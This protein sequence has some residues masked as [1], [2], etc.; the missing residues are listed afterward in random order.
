[1]ESNYNICLVSCTLPMD[2]KMV[3]VWNQ[4]NEELLKNNYKLFLLTTSVHKDLKCEHL[5]IP[6]SL[7]EFYE[8]SIDVT[9]GID[10]EE[11]V[12]A[13]ELT[14]RELEWFN[15]DDQKWEKH[16]TGYFKCKSFYRSIIN[17]LNPS[18]IVAWQ[19][20]LPQSNI[21]KRLGEEYSIP[22]FILE[23]G[24]LPDTFMLESWGNVALS[25]LINS[26]AVRNSILYNND[27]SSFVDIQKYYINNKPA[28]YNQKSYEN[29]LAELNNF[30]PNANH[31][32]V[33]FANV[34]G[35]VGLYPEDTVLSRKTSV[36][37]RNSEETIKAL[38]EAALQIGFNLLIKLHPQDRSDYS[39]FQNNSARI[40]R[41]FNYQLLMEKGDTLAFSCTTLQFEALLYE[42]PI[43]LLANTELS[44]FNIAYEMKNGQNL[45]SVLRKAICRENF[46]EKNQ[47]GKRFLH[48]AADFFL[49]AYSNEL[50]IKNKLA[51][52]AFHLAA[53][54]SFTSIIN[55]DSA[56]ERLYNYLTRIKYDRYYSKPDFPIIIKGKSK[57]L[58]ENLES[59]NPI[60][61]L[62]NL[63]RE[64]EYRNDD[65]EV[66]EKIGKVYYN[67]G[68]Y[69][70]SAEYLSK[71]ERIARAER[72]ERKED[73]DENQERMERIGTTLT[74][75]R[76][77]IENE[78]Y[79]QA[80][81]LMQKL[82]AEDSKNKSVQKVFDLLTNSM[83]SS[84]KEKKWNSKK[85]VDLLIK[86]EELIEKH[87]LEKAKQNLLTVLNFEPEHIEA[88]INLS[89]VYI[90]AND[91]EQSKEIL[92][93]ILIVDP[94]NEIAKGNL[95][96]LFE[97]NYISKTTSDLNEYEKK[98]KKE[99]E[100]Y[101]NQISVHDLPK[102]HSLYTSKAIEP[103]LR[104]MTGV[105]NF[106]DWCALEIDK[107]SEKLNR[108]VY[109]LSIGCGNGDTEIN[110]LQRVK[111][112]DNIEF[113]SLDLNPS[114][115][116]R[117]RASAIK[118]GLKMLYFEEAD[119]NNLSIQRKYDF[120]LANHSLHHVVELE[121]LFEEIEKASSD[122][123]V[124]MINDVIGRNGHV[125]WDGAKE[126]VDYLWNQLDKKYKLNAYSHKYDENILNIDC[127]LE[128]FEGIRAQD[129]LPALVKYFDF[130]M[131][132]PFSLVA[133]KFVD[134]AYGHNFDV[135]NKTD[136][137][138]IQK[139]IDLDIKLL[140]GNK[141]AATQAFIK[142]GKKGMIKNF[143]YIFQTPIETIELRNQILKKEEYSITL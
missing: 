69:R 75:A 79:F 21:L 140:K 117:G 103:H 16:F 66:L 119:F 129:I 86:A 126:I 132:I 55:Y 73:P 115:L 40:V 110:I 49:F 125:L 142:I 80:C 131:Y 43:V 127:S 100:I 56:I 93:Y 4:M 47:N 1:M 63:F 76:E 9:I 102:C 128:G 28:K 53:A 39:A 130:S 51:D 114:M 7:D 29:S 15:K 135:N 31:L 106:N 67:L 17:S 107:L 109:C 57:D 12:T 32:I 50:P 23:R 94:N 141:L 36:N 38:S 96:Y 120:F 71:A 87:K 26:H 44:G 98:M 121:K 95:E 62:K 45:E 42:K 116:E 27:N 74:F 85:S 118:N 82:E 72:H 77:Q 133:H 101:E 18:I 35:S 123:M 90:L 48:W 6:F 124:F 8:L 136:V 46:E 61:L 59:D 89:V 88:L 113:V 91:Y 41:D 3:T 34:D 137:S 58:S 11:K 33:Y 83:D 19:N 5:N 143:E 84:K 24:M 122:E 78:N 99:V 54:G 25:D 14:Q 112:K 60:A 37:Y 97:N 22:S 20:S 68:D 52:M 81:L 108:K 139:I 105:S 2:N 138:I 13:L 92:N 70:N 134:R 10:T 104:E 30:F 65:A 111:Y 64:L